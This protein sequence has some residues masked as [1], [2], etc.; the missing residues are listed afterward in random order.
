MIICR[1]PLRISLLGGG[2]DLPK[3]LNEIGEGDVLTLAI[4]KYIYLSIHELV[5]D[6]GILLK[7]RINEYVESAQQLQHPTAREILTH[8]KLK[9]VDIS[10]TSDIPSG[11]GMG[12]SSSFT[13]GLINLVQA[14]L[15]IPSDTRSIAELACKI[16]IKKLMEPIGSQDQ[17][18]A[19]FGGVRHIRFTRNKIEVSAPLKFKSDEDK[20][21]NNAMYLV[22]VGNQRRA[23]ELLEKQSDDKNISKNLEN[24]AKLSFLAKEG[25]KLLMEKNLQELGQLISL[26]W[27]I[28]KKLSPYI[29]N[30]LIDGIYEEGM[31]LGA[32]GGKLLGAGG[33]GYI[34]FIGSESFGK[35]ITKSKLKVM[36]PKI[37][38]DGSKIV[39]TNE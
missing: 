36:T 23:G 31:K 19:A 17:Y 20:Y 14:Y 39:Y 26:S 1:T 35:K 4:N 33:S 6:Y 29:S 10:V 30:S 28:K 37:D 2:T 12:S 11:T 24:Y 5:E 32:Y 34:L 38:H 16:E 27:E 9:G 25:K 22:R 13:V 8:F 7:Y 15:K 18:I 21:L 3:V